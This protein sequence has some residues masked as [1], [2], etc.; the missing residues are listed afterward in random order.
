M[1]LAVVGSRTFTDYKLLKLTLDELSGIDLIISGG[2]NG[3]DKLVERYA[4]ENGIKTTIYIPEWSKLGRSAGI[5]RNK[6]IVESAD[7][8]VAFWD[9]ISHGTKNSIEL[10]KKANKILKIMK[11]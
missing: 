11:Y 7:M 8:V 3:A 10:A 1:K 9:G 5:I 6:I 2:A 4:F